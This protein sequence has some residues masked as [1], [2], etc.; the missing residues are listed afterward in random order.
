V[1]YSQDSGL[2][3]TR[4]FQAGT[5]REYRNI[6]G[7]SFKSVRTNKKAC[8]SCGISC[9][10]Y[11][12]DGHAR[13]EGPEYESIALCG[14]SIGNSSRAKLIEINALCDDLGLDTIST[15]GVIACMMELTEKKIHDFGIRFGETEKA[16]SLIKDISACTGKGKEAAKGSKQLTEKYGGTEFAMQVKGMELPGYDPRGSWAMGIAYATA[17]RGG[18]HMTAYPIAEE[19][20]GELNPFT[21][22]GKARLV[23][24]MQDAQFAKFSMGVCDF[25]PVSSET[26]GKLYE[27]TYG[28]EWPAEKVNK[29]GERIFNLQ[30]MYNVMAGFTRKEDTLPERFFKELLKDGP[31]KDI[32][33]THEAFSMAIEEYYTIRGW[34]KLGR[35]T[36]E[37][38]EELEIEPD[39][40]AAYRDSL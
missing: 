4:N 19:A 12:V 23:A 36:I 18:C 37:K 39:L 34:D 6:N 20:W 40:I 33:M 9:G 13:V 29:A 10:N 3:P 2:L 28:G 21:F 31:P 5:F 38:L 14:S 25:W 32:P 11:V 26:L 8:F 35:P 15:G 30:R 7:E 17:P 1:D 22:E 16:L 27:A 24:D